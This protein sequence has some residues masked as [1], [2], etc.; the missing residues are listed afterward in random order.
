MPSTLV[1]FSTACAPIS[2]ARNTAVVSVVKNGLPVPPPSSTIRPSARYLCAALRVKSSEISGMTNAD[3][4]PAADDNRH[5]GT[6]LSRRDQIGRHAVQ[7]RLIYTGAMAASEI[8][9]GKLDH[10]ATIDRPCHLRIAFFIPPRTAGANGPQALSERLFLAA[11]SG[12]LSGKVRF[13][14]LDSLAESIA[15]KSSH[16]DR[17]AD[18][19]LSFLDRLGH[20]LAAVVD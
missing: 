10:H 8:F 15:Q 5:F 1:A 16:L 3:K 17:P 2:A 19:T 20:G 4:V 6:Q 9:A 7:G 13:L 11:G 12:D 14:L 18:L